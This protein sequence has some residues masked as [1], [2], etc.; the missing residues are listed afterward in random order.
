MTQTPDTKPGNYYVSAVDGK[1]QAL[2]AGPFR[3]D[4]EG[5]LAM[6]RD[7]KKLAQEFDIKAAFYSYG[8]VR[9][10]YSYHKP[11]MFNRQLGLEDVR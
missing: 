10:E 11:G 2:L 9:T 1:K 4:H 6:V 8:T 5:A 7:A 3:D